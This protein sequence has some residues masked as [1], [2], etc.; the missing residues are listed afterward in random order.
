MSRK[1]TPDQE[2][3]ETSTAATE[4]PPAAE[5]AEPSPGFAEK[6]GQKKWVTAPD[7]YLIGVDP[8]AG[9]KLYE[10]RQD[11]QMAIKFENKPS[12]PVIDKMHE[13]GW[14]WKPADKIW[15]R[16]LWAD[17]ARSTR[18]EAERLYQDVRKMIRQEKGIETSQEVP[19]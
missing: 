14:N 19:F 15:A 7:P 4:T 17:S 2:S 10:S 11:R 13:E 9:V 3:T 5:T 8:V 6:V 18:I 16:P 12:Q 1:R